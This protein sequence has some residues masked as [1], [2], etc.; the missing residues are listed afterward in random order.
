MNTSSLE[1][2]AEDL[3]SHFLLRGGFVV[4]KPKCDMEGADL[5]ALLNVADG[6]KFCRI[7]CKGRSL[8]KSESNKITVPVGYVTD[9]FILVLFVEENRCVEESLYCFF[10]SDIRDWHKTTNGNYYALNFSRSTYRKRI[11]AHLLSDRTVDEIKKKIIDVDVRG[12]FKRMIHCYLDAE[13]PALQGFI[14]LS[15]MPNTPP[16][17]D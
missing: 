12:E 17:A 14:R 4:A 13:L 3:I 16:E 2:I 11:A 1:H 6:A 5:L 8:L 10:G 9:A 15:R 7:Q